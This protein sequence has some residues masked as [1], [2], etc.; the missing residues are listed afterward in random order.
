M[1]DNIVVAGKFVYLSTGMRRI[2]VYNNAV[3]PLGRGG[4]GVVYGGMDCRNCSR[5]AIKQLHP[6]LTSVPALRKRTREESSLTFSHPNIVEMLG[7]C[8]LKSGRGPMFVISKFVEG[9][10]ADDYV[11]TQPGL[12]NSADRAVRIIRLHLPLLDALEFLH[13]QNIRHLDIKP[14]NIMIDN[15]STVKLMDLGV[16]NS[17]M[18]TAGFGAD[19]FGVL[20]TPAFAA[21]EQF[22]VPGRESQVDGRS[23]LYELAVTLYKL[24]CGYNPY[25]D[26]SLQRAYRLHAGECL[27]SH[28]LLPDELHHVLARATEPAPDKRYQDAAAF[29]EALT[30]AITPRPRRR[31]WP[32]S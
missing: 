5:V 22:N 21:P 24:I 15:F 12:F 18:D 16:A 14:S 30:E 1:T 2:Y 23:D 19:E 3:A 17:T 6:R 4:M 8:E 25:E 11:A 32:F 27:P 26:R 13:R 20:G 7:C 28:D 29:K 31:F 10:N 9:R